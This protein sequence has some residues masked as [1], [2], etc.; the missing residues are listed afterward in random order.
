M[1]TKRPRSN[2]SRD[3]TNVDAGLLLTMA[4]SFTCIELRIKEGGACA[5]GALYQNLTYPVCTV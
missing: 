2:R 1:A 4:D 5:T 3:H